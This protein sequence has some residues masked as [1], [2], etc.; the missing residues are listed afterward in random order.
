M[1]ATVRIKSLFMQAK[2]N[3]ATTFRPRRRWYA[4]LSEG[5]ARYYRS[6]FNVQRSDYGVSTSDM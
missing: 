2:Y 4:D 6:M 1:A 5:R 3:E